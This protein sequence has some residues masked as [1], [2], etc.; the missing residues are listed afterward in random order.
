MN[1]DLKLYYDKYS[2]HY[3]SASQ[4]ARVVTESWFKDNMY[5]PFCAKESV[6]DF[7]NNHPITDFYCDECNEEFQLKS[8]RGHLGKVITDGEYNKMM[9]AVN[10]NNTPNFLFLN[11]ESDFH[12]INDLLMIPKEF[13]LPNCI[14]KRKPLSSAA[15]RA[16]WTGCNIHLD[17]ISENGKLYLV[18]NKRVMSI[19]EVTNKVTSIGFIRQNKNVASRGW[20][21][22]I[23]LVISSIQKSMFTL[24]DVYK[25]EKFLKELHPENNHV[26]D[27][28][29][30]Q[31]QILRDNSIIEFLGKG[32]YRKL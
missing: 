19:E 5:C 15:K 18:R 21:N 4:L 26:K 10:A 8:K 23:L 3:S 32:V 7:P 12:F 14:Q 20:I 30:Q 29:R 6:K 9:G 25:Y 16:G 13:I 17:R 31:L 2:S 27:K 28:I 1:I 11:Y 22:D 24:N